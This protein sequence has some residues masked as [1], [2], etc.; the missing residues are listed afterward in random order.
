[1]QALAAA[2]AAPALLAQQGRGRGDNPGPAVLEVTDP[3][4][5][6][7]PVARFFTPAQ[8][9]ALHRL[10]RLVQPPL[11]GNPGAL[12]CGAP[13]FLDFLIGASPADRQQLYRTGLDGLNAQAKKQF[14][15]SFADLDDAQA[16]AIVAPMLV[17]V[18]WPKDPPKEAL[19]AFMFTAREDIAMATRNSPEYAAALASGGRR[20][21]GA[22]Q[23]WKP[24][25]PVYRG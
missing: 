4:A 15:K 5:V 19:K 7:D 8:F 6:A 2:P 18:P 24:I 13:E 22:G 23:V 1:M 17:A 12:D 25:D 9:S 3:D 16:H 21:G 14:S 11:K 10:S 20:G